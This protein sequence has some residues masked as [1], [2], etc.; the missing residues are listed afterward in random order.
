[1]AAE[2]SPLLLRS[3]ASLRSSSK[4]QS[5]AAVINTIP[6][7]YVLLD[8]ASAPKICY[9]YISQGLGKPLS[10]CKIEPLLESTLNELVGESE[11]QSVLVLVK[12]WEPP[13][14]ELW[15]CLSAFPDKNQKFILPLDWDESSIKPIRD[16]HLSEW[17]RFCATLNGW[18]LLQ[19][20]GP[21]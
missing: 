2:F 6:V 14:G 21:L 7:P 4:E 18:Q 17:R 8:W 10:V 9:E 19:L 3:E 13:L 16:N 20:D 11:N 5:L 12:S 1:M 15:D